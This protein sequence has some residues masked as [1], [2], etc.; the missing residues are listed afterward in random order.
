MSALDLFA[1]A[2]GAF[3][4][5][6][7]VLFPY[8]LKNSTAMQAIN[9]KNKELQQCQLKN[10]EQQQ[11]IAQLQQ[12]TQQQSTTLAQCEQSLRKNFLVVVIKWSAAK[13]DIDLHVTDPSGAEFYFR[14]KTISGRPGELSTDTTNGPGIEIW[15]IR[16]PPAGDYKIRYDFYARN[17]NNNYPV[18]KGEIYYRDGRTRFHPVR[19]TRI[20]HPELVATVTVLA[21]GNINIRN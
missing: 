1:S 2:M 3:A 11:K 5:I 17:G 13:Q 8:Y 19:L 10:K 12:Q 6:A 16:N 20:K 7:V 4:L 14:H 9:Q 15:E 18:V 21:N